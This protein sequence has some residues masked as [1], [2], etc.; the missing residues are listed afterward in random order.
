MCV[1][2]GAIARE[3]LSRCSDLGLVFSPQQVGASRRAGWD[4]ASRASIL[5]N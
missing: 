3:T 5:I 4:E 2:W 1:C